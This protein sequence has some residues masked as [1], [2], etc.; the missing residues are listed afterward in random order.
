MFI[1]AYSYDAI[2][3]SQLK[4]F[5]TNCRRHL[6][7]DSNLFWVALQSNQLADVQAF[8]DSDFS[9]ELSD[10]TKEL[11]EAGWIL[12][13]LKSN[14]RNQVNISNIMVEYQGNA[15]RMQ[16][17]IEKLQSGSNIIGEFPILIKIKYLDWDKKK[18]QLLEYCFQEMKKKDRKNVVV[19]Y[20]DDCSFFKDVG[21]D[22]RRLSKDKIV[23]E[24]PSSQGK[25]KD[26]SNI[27]NFIEQNDHILFTRRDYFNGCE[28]SNIIYLNGSSNGVRNCLMRGVQNVI[29]IQV[30]AYTSIC[31]M[32]E[33]LIS[34]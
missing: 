17:S 10:M 3:V 15:Y 29:C 21:K 25:Q 11:K 5:I 19:L 24:Y 18:D 33:Y 6:K 28:A 31:G 16:S 30:D 8:V 32:K 7:N 34:H 27:K 20:D 12:P 4:V 23:V 2:S 14:M 22:L 9:I 1:S 13:E 26:I